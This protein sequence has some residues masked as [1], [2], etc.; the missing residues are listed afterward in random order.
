VQ[1]EEAVYTNIE[2]RINQS[3]EFDRMMQFMKHNES[4]RNQELE[5]ERAVLRA[6][7]AKIKAVQVDEAIIE[8]EEAE[9]NAGETTT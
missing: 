3:T 6:E 5:A 7:V 4:I 1:P 8:A 2:P 9:E